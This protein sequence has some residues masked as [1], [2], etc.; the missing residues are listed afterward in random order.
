MH[1]G[2]YHFSENEELTSLLDN[3][4]ECVINNTFKS[5][6]NELNDFKE[7]Y[8]DGDNALPLHTD[9]IIMQLFVLGYYFNLVH[10]EEISDFALEYLTF[11]VDSTLFRESN[12]ENVY[13]RFQ[14]TLSHYAKNLDENDLL[15][16]A[17]ASFVSLFVSNGEKI[18]SS[19]EII[20]KVTTGYFDS[21]K[22]L[23]ESY[24]T[25]RNQ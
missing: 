5:Y 10:G 18:E 7:N 2:Y 16:G 19:V 21:L 12:S 4:Y 9:L 3:I 23:V 15:T 25:N 20:D 6:Q 14:S 11:K 1:T 8:V 24:S 17:A 22:E 13:D